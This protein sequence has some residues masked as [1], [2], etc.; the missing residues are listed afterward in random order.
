MADELIVFKYRLSY[1]FI[2]SYLRA[3]RSDR[4]LEIAQNTKS[5]SKL[6]KLLEIQEVAKKLPRNLRKV[7]QRDP[8]LSNSSTK[9]ERTTFLINQSI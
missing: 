2:L 9:S 3:L 1:L 6:K 8:T 7:L 5:Y 4:K